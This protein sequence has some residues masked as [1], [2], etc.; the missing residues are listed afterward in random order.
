LLQEYQEKI[1]GLGIYIKSELPK[2]GLFQKRI[3]PGKIFYEISESFKKQLPPNFIKT[4]FSTNIN[5]NELTIQVYPSEEPV[6]FEIENEEIICS[7]KTNSAG[8]GYHAFLVESVLNVANDVK[9]D[10]K[11]TDENED[12]C[13]ETGYYDNRDFGFLQQEMLKWLRSLC[14]HLSESNSTENTMI[15]MP[16]GYSVSDEYDV[17]SP[18]GFWKKEWVEGVANAELPELLSVGDQFFPWW[19]K[20]F[21]SEFWYKCGMTNLWV[22]FAW[23]TAINEEE[24][25]KIE[26]VLEC[27]AMAKK[28]NNNIAVPEKEIEFLKD[29][30]N[31]ELTIT[32][33]K[34]EGI[35]YKKRNMEKPL[36]GKWKITIPGYFYDEVENDSDTAI[37]WHQDKTIRGSSY[38]IEGKTKKQL[39]DDE[40]P[41]G[42]TF[43]FEKDHLIGWANF[44]KSL[45]EES[46]YWVLSGKM[47]TNN[48]LCIVTICF[49]EE[50]DKDW[51]INTWKTVF[52]PDKND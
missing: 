22:D 40:K 43:S 10:W 17:M 25:K 20:G 45:E 37:Y 23:H 5:D 7:A 14:R 4:I 18:M 6:Y 1:L 41:E 36:T 24:R 26:F 29:C 27:F 46:D 32:P 52:M 38:L 30:L 34:P 21:T 12:C 19:D 3:N 16:I 42:K 2:K 13:D 44:E 28:S 11:W 49:D 50:K 35:G 33:P 48:N 51:A 39:F 8:P 47:A 31:E 15:S 9:L